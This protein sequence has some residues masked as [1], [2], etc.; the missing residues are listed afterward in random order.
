VTATTTPTPERSKLGR[1]LVTL[2]I[3][4]MVSMWVYVLYLAFGPGRADSPD[5]IQAP[6]FASSAQATCDAALDKVAALQPA[7]QARDALA[8][9]DTLDDANAELATML[10]Q[11]KD[12][13]P[14]GDDGV[15]VT[16][17]LR[18]WGTYLQDREDYADALRANPRA[19]LYVTE[20]SGNQITEYIDQFAKD[21]EIPACST[22]GDVG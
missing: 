15:V 2:A 17:W 7:P 4:L 3:V 10:D 5:R 13:T 14:A 1:T 16:R 19:R 8:R 12:L 18:D 20:K 21:N 9:A 6:H 11:L 22:P